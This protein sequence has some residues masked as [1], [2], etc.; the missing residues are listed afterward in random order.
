MTHVHSTS[1]VLAKAIE[2]DLRD[3]WMEIQKQHPKESF[4]AFGV[5]TD[6]DACGFD[7]FACGEQ[8]LLAEGQRLIDEGDVS[9]CGLSRNLVGQSTSF[10]MNVGTAE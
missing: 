7:P 1:I 6:E 4:Y 5:F 9:T 10:D 3:A 2:A 8:R